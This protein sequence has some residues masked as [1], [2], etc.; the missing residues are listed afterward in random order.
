VGLQK[1]QICTTPLSEV[2][3]GVKPLDQ[4]LVDLSSVL[5]M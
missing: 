3:S 5:A 2:V 1:G 4:S